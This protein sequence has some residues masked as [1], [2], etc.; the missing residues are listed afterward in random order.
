MEG[1]NPEVHILQ[2]AVVSTPGVSSFQRTGSEDENRTGNTTKPV[3][4]D[5]VAVGE[6]NGV[7]IKMIPWGKNND[8]PTDVITKMAECGVG[9]KALRFSSKAHLGRGYSFFTESIENNKYVQTIVPQSE[10]GE[11][12]EWFKTNKIKRYLR[13]SVEDYEWFFI[14]FAE[15]IFSKNTKAANKIRHKEAV[16]CRI[17]EPVEI[18]GL[19]V[20][21]LIYSSKFLENKTI[22][23]ED[24]EV[25]VMP[26]INPY[27]TKEEIQKLLKKF[28]EKKACWVSS[29][30]TVGRFYYPDADWH[31]VIRNQWVDITSMVP[32]TKA[33]IMRHQ[34]TIKY[35]IEID[36]AYWQEAFPKTESSKGWGAMNN[37]ERKKAITDT[38]KNIEETLA[39]AINAGKSIQSPMVNANGKQNSYWKITPI[40]DKLKDGAYIPDSEAANSEVLFAIGVDPSL[41]G[42]GSPGGKLGAGSGSD[43]REAFTIFTALKTP[44]REVILEPLEFIQEY[45]NLRTDLKIGFRDITITTLDKNPTGQQNTIS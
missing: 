41:I 30:P 40:D 28:E 39:G 22:N 20:S 26:I 6:L 25:E 36:K 2:H 19:Y 7:K 1:S 27:W 35:H 32:A 10:A 44:D 11:L 24:N 21:F 43:K 45:N 8:W 15:I 31:S 9:K 3:V 38:L 16:F 33:A 14:S 29:Y 23:I 18:D 37:D 17:S 13:S 5:P 42:K 4:V 34:T 12:G